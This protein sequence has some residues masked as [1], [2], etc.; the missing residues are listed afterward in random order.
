MVG[1]ELNQANGAGQ[2]L[3][4]FGQLV[5]LLDGRA[6]TGSN[7]PKVPIFH[8]K[9]DKVSEWLELLEQITDKVTEEEKFRQISKYVWWEMRP[10]VMRVATEAAE[11]WGNFKAEMQRRYQLGDD[12]LTTEDLKRLE[13]SDF[14]TV[15]AFATAFEKMARKVPGLAEESQCAIFLSNLTECESVSLTR[16]GAIGRKLTWETVKQSLADGEL[17]QVYEFQMKQQRHKRKARVVTEGA[18]GYPSV[19]TQGVNWRGGGQQQQL[20]PPPQVNQPSQAAGQRQ[21][22]NHG[23]NGQSSQGRGNRGRERGNGNSGQGGQGGGRGV[24]WNGQ[25]GN[26]RPKFDWRN[27]ICHHCALKGHTFKFCQIRKVDEGNGLISTNMD[28]DV[29]DM[30]GKYIDPKIAGGMCKEALRRAER[31]PPPPAMFRLWKEE[32][33]RSTIKVEELAN[34]ESEEDIRREEPIVIEEEEE[35]ESYCQERVIDTMER[36]ED[37][38]EKMQRLNLQMRSICDEVAKPMVYLLGSETGPSSVKPACQTLGSNPRSGITFR[39]PRG[40][41]T[42]PQAVCTRIP[43]EDGLDIEVLVDRLLEGHNDLLNLKDILAFAPKLREGFK[44]RLFRRRVASVR[45]GDLIPAEHHWAVPGTKMDWKSVGTGSVNLSIKGKPCS[46]MLDTGAEMNINKESD[47][48]R[49][50]MDIDRINSGFLY[51]ASGKTPFTGTASNVVIEIEK[52]KVRSCFFVMPDLDHPLL[53]GRSFLCRTELMIL[54]KHDDT[55]YVILSDPVCGNYEIITCHNTGPRSLRNRPNPG[56]YT[57]EESEGERRRLMGEDEEE[58]EPTGEMCLSLTSINDAMEIVS[59]YGMADPIDVQALRARIVEDSGEGEVKLVYRL[60][61]RTRP[62]ALGGIPIQADV[63]GEERPLR[64]ESRTLNDTKRNYSQFKR[65]TLAVLH[66]LRVFRYLFGR[67]FVLRVDPTALAGSLKNYAPP[68]PTIARWLTYVWM[69]DFELERI[70]GNKNRADG[71]SRINWDKSG[72]GVNE[73]I[74][75]VDAFLDEEEDVKL[76]INAHVVGISGVIMQ[77]QSAFLAPARYVKRADIVLK[78]FVE[79]DPWGGK[80]VEWMAKLALTETF[81]VGEDPMAIESGAYSVD[82]QARYAAD[83]SFLVNSIVQVHEDGEGSQDPV[84]DMEEDEFEEGEITEAFRADEYEGARE[85]YYWEGMSEMISKYCESCVPCQIRASTLYKEPLHPRIVRDAGAVVHLDLL[86][87]PQGVGSYNIFFDARDNLTG[88][89]DGRV[90]RSKTGETLVLCI[91]EYFLRYPFIVEFVMDRGLEF[92]CGEV[93]TLLQEYGVQAS[94]T[95]RAHPQANAPVE[96][97]HTTI[98]NLLAKWTNG[99]ENQWP[100][101]LRAAFFVENITIKRSTKYAPAT[102]WYGRHATLPIESFLKTWRR[103][104]MESTLS[105]EELLDLRARQVGIAEERIQEAADRVSDSRLEDKERWDLLPRVR[106]EP[107]EVGDVVVLYD[108]S[109]E[110]QWLR[111]LDKRWLGPYRIRRCGQHGAYEIEEL[112]GTPWRDWVSG[113]EERVAQI[114]RESLDWRQFA[115]RMLRLQPQPIDRQGR[116]MSF[117]GANLDEFLEVFVIFGD[118]QRWT[119]AQRVRQVRHW[120]VPDLRHEVSAMSHTVQ[121]WAELIA[122]LRG[123]FTAERRRRLRREVGDYIPVLRV[124]PRARL[125]KDEDNEGR[126]RQQQRE[127]EQPEIPRR[128]RTGRRRGRQDRG[129]DLEERDHVLI[130]DVGKVLPTNDLGKETLPIGS[131]RHDDSSTPEIG[132]VSA[133]ETCPAEI[134]I[135]DRG[136]PETDRT[137]PPTP[138]QDGEEASLQLVLTIASIRPTEIDTMEGVVPDTASERP[139]RW[140]DTRAMAL[141]LPQRELPLMIGSA[142]IGPMQAHEEPQ[143]E[144]PRETTPMHDELGYDGQGV[145]SRSEPTVE[146]GER[147]AMGS[148]SLDG[149]PLLSESRL[150]EQP[151]EPE[152]SLTAQLYDMESPRMQMRQEVS[153]PSPMDMETERVEA[154]VLGLDKEGL[155]EDMQTQ[156]VE[157][158]PLDFGDTPRRDGDQTTANM[159]GHI[160]VGAEHTQD[161]SPTYEEESLPKSRGLIDHEPVMRD[162][163]LAEEMGRM[164]SLHFPGWLAFERLGQ[165]ARPH[166]S[167]NYIGSGLVAARQAIEQV[168][169]YTRRVVIQS[170]ELSCD[171]QMEHDALREVVSGLRTFVEGKEVQT[172]EEA[173]AVLKIQEREASDWRAQVQRVLRKYEPAADATD[174]DRLERRVV[175]ETVRSSQLESQMSTLIRLRR[176]T[177]EQTQILFYE[178]AATAGWQEE[179]RMRRWTGEEPMPEGERTQ[180]EVGLQARLLSEASVRKLAGVMEH[181]RRLTQIEVARGE[182]LHDAVRRIGVLE[183]ENMGLRDMVHNLVTNA[184]QARQSTSR[185]EQRIT[186]VEEGHRRREED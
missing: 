121:A 91:S 142:T 62:T 8:F 21:G 161:A 32:D 60:P 175:L 26:D 86:A 73:D 67:R 20:T 102:L 85:L 115:R 19:P 106:K 100:K 129:D 99:R 182:M 111:K 120:V 144:W 41:P 29:Y 96:R 119:E 103:Q 70:P 116:P 94:Y 92:R 104:D 72:D 18:E 28:G 173:E 170:F 168:R 89:V 143:P 11:N 185:L 64:F 79:E 55:M 113:Y 37:L 146:D 5:A 10:E 126:L 2:R 69:F 83:I 25:G 134:G 159:R 61:A 44:T 124:R 160:E 118:G 82:T 12:L 57:F 34:S 174:R 77:G 1:D 151:T 131:R 138:I 105:F 88:F 78:D 80:D 6:V 141:D 114:V 164:P 163:W 139:Y 165:A 97:G 140:R 54:N 183:Q 65:E 50:G 43:L 22:Q 38:V 133:T 132:T 87:M 158:S 68:D 81:R 15:G 128:P 53:L 9:G 35:E 90:I 166:L 47:A 17:D 31:G 181:V 40:Q 130:S 179:V 156:R 74:P 107:L 49:L 56:S 162:A 148:S 169:D 4:T 155:T 51:G 149:S 71:L 125:E 7:I 14:T 172:L 135:R 23:G 167:R 24:N 180:A 76:H 33:A 109:L 101:H 59:S 117:D 122:T 84:R 13:R 46:G 45:L 171:R 184:E 58:C 42:F 186:D 30:Y 95:I 177:E 178:D 108:S 36:M 157:T 137:T 63:N 16:R 154:E 152:G 123:A 27:A 176:E 75:P 112:N 127:S 136:A 3:V 66:Y 52:V 145:Q 48:L 110:K 150:A 153:Q 98:T 147:G 39:P 93:R